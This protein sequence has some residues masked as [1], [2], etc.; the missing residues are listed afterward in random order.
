MKD[1]SQDLE[2]GCPKLAF[3]KFWGVQIFKVNHNVMA[4]IW[5]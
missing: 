1:L 4:I 3:E 5:R 2:S